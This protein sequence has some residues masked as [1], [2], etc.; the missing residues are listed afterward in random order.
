MNDQE[1][2]TMLKSLDDIHIYE[3]D[4]NV[5]SLEEYDEYWAEH[6]DDND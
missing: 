3:P 4:C 2:D 5:K 1:F 6:C